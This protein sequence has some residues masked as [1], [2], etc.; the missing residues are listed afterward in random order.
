MYA[1]HNGRMPKVLTSS[2]N[3]ELGQVEY[4][5]S[6]KTGTLTQNEMQFKYCLIGNALYGD[7]V[8]Q[9]PK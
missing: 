5:F 7:K 1:P 2:F 6:D 3:E 4:I 9:K 8:P